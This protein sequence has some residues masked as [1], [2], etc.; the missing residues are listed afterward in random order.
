MIHELQRGEHIRGLFGTLK[1]LCFSP[2]T[3]VNR[4]LTY[5]KLRFMGQLYQFFTDSTS[6]TDWYRTILGFGSCIRSDLG[7]SFWLL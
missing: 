5:I 6:T 2:C 3:P 7:V 1:S 4:L